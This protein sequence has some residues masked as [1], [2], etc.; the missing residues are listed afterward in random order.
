MVK[1]Y[2]EIIKKFWE[3]VDYPSSQKYKPESFKG[4]LNRFRKKYNI[5]D[6]NDSGQV[7]HVTLLDNVV[8]KCSNVNN[9]SEKNDTNNNGVNDINSLFGKGIDGTYLNNIYI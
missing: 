7:D 5:T 4:A 8:N 3:I 9:F 2:K 6:R 1:I